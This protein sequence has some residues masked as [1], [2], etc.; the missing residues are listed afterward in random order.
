[1]STDRKTCEI[2]I[3]IPTLNEA[4]CIG[5]TVTSLVNTPGVE[6]IV[7][8]GG[9]RDQT[10]TEASGAGATVITSPLGR[11][12]QQNLGANAATGQVLLFLHADTRLP[13][14]FVVHVLRALAQPDVVAGA[15]RF[16]VDAT[17]WRFRLLE[18]CTNWRAARFS[19]P[20]GDQALF[21]PAARFRAMGGFREFP[22]LEDVELV[23]RLKK[24]GRIALVKTAALTSPRRWQHLGLVHTTVL[25]QLILLGFYCGIH[26]E[27]LARWYGRRGKGNG[28]FFGK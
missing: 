9:S 27:R 1:M 8:D 26:P 16:A 25:N 4:A 17:G 10:A 21:V 12:N 24:T 22:L 11:G 20:Y 3:I 6:V 14:D 18:Q 28:R 2:S 7:V 19:L 15:F 23:L 13:E 5:K